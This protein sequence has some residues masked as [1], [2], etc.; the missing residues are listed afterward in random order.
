MADERMTPRRIKAVERI[1]DGMAHR[2]SQRDWK[3]L[4]AELLGAVRE[5]RL[6]V[7]RLQVFES[8]LSNPGRGALLVHPAHLEDLCLL[9]NNIKAEET[10]AEG[11]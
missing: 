11:T 5:E 3:L 9:A 4:C 7:K 1:V 8:L 2:Y 6:E 10:D